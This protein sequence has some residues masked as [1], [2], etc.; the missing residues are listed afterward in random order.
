MTNDGDEDDDDNGQWED[1]KPFT[2]PV[3]GIK[4]HIKIQ[5][6]GVP[7]V[8]NSIVEWKSKNFRNVWRS[9]AAGAAQH[10][11]DVQ[12]RLVENSVDLLISAEW[13]S[14]QQQN[15]C[16]T[17]RSLTSSNPVPLWRRR[18]RKPPIAPNWQQLS[19]RRSSNHMASEDTEKITIFV[20]RQGLRWHESKHCEHWIPSISFLVAMLLPSLLVFCLY[21]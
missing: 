15:D 11:T 7:R 6:F 4:Q 18:R 16:C 20:F 19:I 21:L 3:F 13:W 2:L 1:G 17:I 14:P 9:L 10:N 5:Y 8:D 12:C